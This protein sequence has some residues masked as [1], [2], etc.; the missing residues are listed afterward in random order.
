MTR[1]AGKA[2]RRMGMMAREDLTSAW[3]I[4][5]KAWRS[6]FGLFSKFNECKS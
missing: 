6:S 2:F 1:K 3:N 4:T 5:S